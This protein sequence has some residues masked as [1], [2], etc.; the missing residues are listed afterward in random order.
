[1][2]GR[3]VIGTTAMWHNNLQTLNPL[4]VQR[5]IHLMSLF[6]RFPG[7]VTPHHFPWVISLRAMLH[8]CGTNS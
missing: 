3:G 5:L 2:G 1:M 6:P 4:V 8:T 7:L